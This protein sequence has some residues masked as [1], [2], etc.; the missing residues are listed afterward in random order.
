MTKILKGIITIMSL[1]AVVLFMGTTAKAAEED[2][3]YTV[4]NGEACITV[5]SGTDTDVVIPAELGGYPVTSIG[6]YAFY[7]CMDILSISVPAT[8]TSLGEYA[9]ATCW[10]MTEIQLPAGLTSMG[11][12]VFE[13]CL[14]LQSVTIPSGVTELP[15]NAFTMCGNLV[16]VEL[17]SAMTSI[18]AYAFEYCT[19]LSEITIPESVTAIGTDAFV[20]C[21]A[22]TAVEI[23]ATVTEI[24][25]YAFGYSKSPSGDHTLNEDFTITGVITSAAEEYATANGITFIATGDIVKPVQ[26]TGVRAVYED[27]VIKL[28]WDDCGAKQYRV[29]RFDGIT[30]GYTTLTF[31]AT[32]EGYVDSDL[33]EAH[34]YFYRIVGYFEDINGDLASGEVSVA[35]AVVA[36]DKEPGKV[37]TLTASVVDGAVT[38][39][40]EAPEGVRYYKVVRAPEFS[41]GYYSCLQY[42][43]TDTT[44]TDTTASPGQYRY[45]VVGYYKDVDGSWVYGGFSTAM[46]VTIE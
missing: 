11:A 28:T 41:G 32:A 18:G 7:A 34:R 6:D 40:W 12:G 15:D 1:C 31:R 36:T 39:D 22:L 4:E 43:V 35:A 17:P 46:F 42:N 14:D 29:M 26:V 21:D 33:I 2:Y 38:L 24:G 25:E 23:P 10:S 5:Y 9:F 30:S 37:T 3:E 19:A 44:Y 27:G 16:T 13:Y 20:N 8:V 45:K